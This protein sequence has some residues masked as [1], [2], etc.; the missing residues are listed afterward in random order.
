[1]LAGE[2]AEGLHRLGIVHARTLSGARFLRAVSEGRTVAPEHQSAMIWPDSTA[3]SPN[4][5][6]GA[7]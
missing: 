1:M 4:T 3:G 2:V 7:V 6:T 5:A